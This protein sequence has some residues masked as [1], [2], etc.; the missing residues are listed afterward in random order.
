MSIAL[1]VCVFVALGTLHAMR[2]R[3]IVICAILF[4]ISHKQHDF[5]KKKNIIQQAAQCV[6]IF[7]RPFINYIIFFL[8]LCL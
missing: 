7:L 1:S 2:I 4:H 6:H 5:Q 3:H 8:Q